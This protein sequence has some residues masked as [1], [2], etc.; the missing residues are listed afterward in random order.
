MNISADSGTGP[1]SLPASVATYDGHTFTSPSIYVAFHNLSA[2]D[3]CGRLDTSN[4]IYSTMLAFQPGELSTIAAPL[5]WLVSK[6]SYVATSS[7][8]FGGIHS[9]LPITA[10]ENEGSM[11]LSND[12][13]QSSAAT[14]SES[15][16]PGME[17]NNPA[18]NGLG[19]G[20]IA[21]ESAATDSGR[22]W[23]VTETSA[24][25]LYIQGFGFPTDQAATSNAIFPLSSIDLSILGQGNDNSDP[26][27]TPVSSEPDT[28]QLNLHPVLPFQADSTAPRAAFSFLNFYGA[29]IALRISNSP[30]SIKSK[31]CVIKSHDS[32]CLGTID[33]RRPVYSHN[34]T[35]I[36]RLY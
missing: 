35:T 33:R 23:V 4:V 14:E 32:R 29:T 15:G 2:T 11:I 31:R 18:S 19:K 12:F 6:N 34:C 7:Y 16:L 20:S 22:A 10:V 25:S 13:L 26:A 1:R 17:T 30:Q 28:D 8:N 36:F 3:G 21:T 5:A 27:P 24:A 9:P